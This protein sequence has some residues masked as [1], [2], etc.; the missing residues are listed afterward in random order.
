MGGG[1]GRWVL[2]VE[3]GRGCLELR[4]PDTGRR[5]LFINSVDSY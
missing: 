5:L 4:N 3:R 2:A 1:R